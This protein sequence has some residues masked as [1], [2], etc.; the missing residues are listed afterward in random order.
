MSTRISIDIPSDVLES[1]GMMQYANRNKLATRENKNTF[2]KKVKIEADKQLVSIQNDTKNRAVPEYKDDEIFRSSA[3]DN[4]SWLAVWHDQVGSYDEDNP[5][6]GSTGQ[7]EVSMANSRLTS[8]KAL[9]DDRYFANINNL[10]FLLIAK[11]PKSTQWNNPSVSC[12]NI[13]EIDPPGPDPR[14]FP[15]NIYNNILNGYFSQFV[16]TENEAQDLS[17]NQLSQI[18]LNTNISVIEEF[19]NRIR[20]GIAAADL[21]ERQEVNYKGIGFIPDCLGGSPHPFYLFA[22]KWLMRKSFGHIF[23]S[24]LKVPT[25]RYLYVS[26]KNID[27]LTISIGLVKDY[28]L[29]RSPIELNVSSANAAKPKYVQRVKYREAIGTSY[30]ESQS[31]LPSWVRGNIVEVYKIEPSRNENTNELIL[32]SILRVSITPFSPLSLKNNFP[33]N[34]NN[35]LNGIHST[36]NMEFIKNSINA[37]LTV[38]LSESLYGID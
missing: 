18:S 8:S 30:N 15:E 14:F 26:L 34:P 1:A 4:F 16:Y 12:A 3:K 27:P 10:S 2:K 33:Y 37:E 20:L 5:G 11:T 19:P 13:G 23:L 17:F 29:D 21:Y 9:S 25:T 38:F 6:G 36:I 35:P 7:I 24:I 22:N 32:P 31:D 28:S